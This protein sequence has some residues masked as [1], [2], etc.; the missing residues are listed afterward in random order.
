MNRGFPRGFM[1]LAL[2]AVGSGLAADEPQHRY[3]IEQIKAAWDNRPTAVRARWSE[4]HRPIRAEDHA[5]ESS[6]FDERLAS[7]Q[8]SLRV[9]VSLDV[10]R[11]RLSLVGRIGPASDR[12]DEIRAFDG[13]LLRTYSRSNRN[14]T[15]AANKGL[16]PLAIP[17]M[18]A[19]AFMHSTWG[20]TAHDPLLAQGKMTL[21]PHV[22][23]FRGAPCV[24]VRT[25]HTQVIAKQKL[26][27]DY[28][29][30]VD[31]QQ[32]FAIVRLRSWSSGKRHVRYDLWHE[33]RDGLW[34]PTRWIVQGFNLDSGR[35]QYFAQAVVDDWS[36]APNFAR[37]EFSIEFP[38]GTP[39]FDWRDGK[40]YRQ[41]PNGRLEPLQPQDNP[42]GQ[43][44]AAIASARR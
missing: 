25:Y 18:G 32:D 16:V 36:V 23:Q 31:P 1:I 30:C 38:I 19:R 43:V 12:S 4:F 27:T 10:N 13:K 24:I 26:R 22:E 28:E 44:D 39:I 14:G 21:L 5:T 40:D 34:R 20:I 8:P 41:G 9:G 17:T 6:D 37:S 33:K 15:I 3:V 7:G 29:L 35:K 42:P 11:S 2:C